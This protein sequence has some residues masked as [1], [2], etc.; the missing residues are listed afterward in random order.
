MRP[1]VLP[2]VRMT[3]VVNR[4]RRLRRPISPWRHSRVEDRRKEGPRGARTNKAIDKKPYESAKK[5][6]TTVREWERRTPRS[7]LAPEP[8]RLVISEIRRPLLHSEIT[9]WGLR[10]PR[11]TWGSSSVT[12]F[13]RD[14]DRTQRGVLQYYKQ[15]EMKTR[16]RI[17]WICS[18]WKWWVRN[19]VGW[20]EPL[21][22]AHK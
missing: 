2:T 22:E 5:R 4:V 9:S 20:V 16:I 13:V 17:I 18:K 21:K 12:D 6:S 15:P 8:R 1:S 14:G 3:A 19:V 10:P 11:H 7:S